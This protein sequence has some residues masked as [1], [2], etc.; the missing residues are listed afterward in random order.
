[1]GHGVWPSA[2]GT[3]RTA[4][5]CL[6][7]GQRAGRTEA[8]LLSL[9]PSL[10]PPFPISHERQA[11]LFC[12]KNCLDQGFTASLTIPECTKVGL[13]FSMGNAVPQWIM[14]FQ[15]DLGDTWKPTSTCQVWLGSLCFEAV[16][17]QVQ[18]GTQQW[19]LGRELEISTRWKI[20]EVS[21]D[22]SYIRVLSYISLP[23]Y[24]WLLAT[25]LL[26]LAPS[27]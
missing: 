5:P 15:D 14:R 18:T 16:M 8:L 12:S 13:I 3:W 6:V 27:S 10:L 21:K 23:S 11:P 20:V 24:F 26:C 25:Q 4:L 19:H 2:S 17:S 7:R 22:F 9:L 1:M